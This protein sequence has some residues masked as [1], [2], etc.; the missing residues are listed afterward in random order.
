MKSKPLKLMIYNE[1][2]QQVWH[3]VLDQ[4]GDR[5]WHLWYQLSPHNPAREEIWYH[6]LDE[7]KNEN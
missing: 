7:I 2:K 5:T 4:V 1:V 3:K 6:I